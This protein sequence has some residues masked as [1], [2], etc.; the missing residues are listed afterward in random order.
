MSQR[1]KKDSKEWFRT[2][3]SSKDYLEVYRHRNEEDARNLANLIQRSIPLNQGDKVLDVCCG[4]GRHSIEFALR[5]FDVTGF[6]L[7]EFLIFEAVKNLSSLK[8]K[9][10][11]VKFLIKDMLKFNFKGRF[12][13]VLN[14]FTSFAYFE[15]DE[16]NFKVIKN[17][18]DSL[19]AGGYFVFDFINESNLRETLVPSDTMKYGDST[20]TQTR[21]IE[22]DFI[23]KDIVIVKES[24]KLKFTER[25]KLYDKKTLVSVFKSNNLTIEHCFGDYYGNKFN[26]EN[27]KRLILIARKA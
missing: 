13:A 24:R 23:Y 7:S 20:Y 3:F 6:D 11:K 15:N 5:G 27:S 10:L 18:S 17:V 2:W 1:T 19:T 12:N 22:N 4:A 26:N 21:R 8:D 16:K 25:L 9:N 14:L